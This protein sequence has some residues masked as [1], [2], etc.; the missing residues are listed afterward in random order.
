MNNLIYESLP[1]YEN[2]RE[3]L[4]E[5][6]YQR[7][8]Y[9]IFNDISA[10]EDLDSGYEICTINSGQIQRALRN[11]E[12]AIAGKQHAQEAVFT[13]LN[14]VLGSIKVILREEA[15]KSVKAAAEM[16]FERVAA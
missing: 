14:Y 6:E 8:L 2:L 9:D 5:R 7:L 13:A 1:Y 12:D 3:L 4:V 15:D 16:Q 11:L 10:F